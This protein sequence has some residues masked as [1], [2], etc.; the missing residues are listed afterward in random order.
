MNLLHSPVLLYRV[1][2]GLN[3]IPDGTYVDC[4]F[5]RGGHSINILKK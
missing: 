2:E 1:I 4:T 3:I 5:G